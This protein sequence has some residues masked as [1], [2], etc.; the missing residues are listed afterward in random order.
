MKLIAML[1]R[2]L[3]ALLIATVAG[4]GGAAAQG[5][6]TGSAEE[7]AW[8]E[9]LARGNKAAFERYLELYPAGTYATE[10]FRCVIVLSQGLTDPSCAVETAAGPE[11]GG[12]DVY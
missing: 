11:Q 1:Y 8:Q 2:S 12:G 4:S 7:L 10:A 6:Q 3:Q 9:A 5:E